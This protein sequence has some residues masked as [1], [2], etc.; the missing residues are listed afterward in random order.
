MSPDLK[1]DIDGGSPTQRHADGRAPRLS[2]KALRSV[3]KCRRIALGNRWN[4]RRTGILNICKR[5]W[6]PIEG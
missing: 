5:D 3:W 6:R 4:G 2:A 1:R